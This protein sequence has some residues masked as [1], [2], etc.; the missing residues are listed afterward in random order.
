MCYGHDQYYINQRYHCRMSITSVPSQ[1]TM[2][3]PERNQ[4]H[5]SGSKSEDCLIF[6]KKIKLISYEKRGWGFS[7]LPSTAKT[8]KQ[9]KLFLNTGGGQCL[10]PSFPDTNCLR[11]PR[12]SSP[13]YTPTMHSV[14][15]ELRAEPSLPWVLL[16]LPQACSLVSFLY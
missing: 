7:H 8:M 9:V 11:P 15:W 1:G 3:F 12:P 4:Y 10:L 5:D 16:L 6:S 14:C 2:P 13:S